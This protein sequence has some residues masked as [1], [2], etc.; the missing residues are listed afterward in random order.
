MAVSK[1]YEDL[2]ALLE[3]GLAN[4]ADSVVEVRAKMAELHGHPVGDDMVIEGV[5]LLGVPSAK[6][7]TPAALES[8]TLVLQFHGGAFVSCDLSDY[9]F[10]GEKISRACTRPVL[11]IGYRLAPEYTCPAPIQDCAQAYRGLLS[12]GIDPAKIALIGDSCGGGLVVATLVMLRDAGDPLPACA[13]TLSGWFDLEAAGEAAVH[14]LGKDPFFDAAWL[15]A[16]GRDYVGPDGDLRAPLA[17]P[18]YADLAGLPPLLLQAGGIDG[19]RDDSVRLA[20][21]ARAAGVA[22]ELEISEDMIHGWHGLP[23]P[24]ATAALSRVAD[25][26]AKHLD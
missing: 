19:T 25:F 7:A 5:D 9:L 2:L 18:L 15:R 14:P 11:E 13:V 4:P 12:R 8:D 26:F 17:S 6:I 1:E 22:V 24:E 3:Q 20:E 23:V 16:R 21:R 10:Y